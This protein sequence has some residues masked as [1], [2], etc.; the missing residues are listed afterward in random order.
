MPTNPAKDILLGVAVG[1]AIGVPVEFLD[2]SKMQANPL[3]GLKGYGTYNLPPGTWSDDTSLTLCLA[4]AL[5]EQT[6]DPELVGKYF[7]RW[8]YRSYWTANGEVFD[9]GITTREAIQRISRGTPATLAGGLDERENGNGSLMRILPLVL[10][11]KNLPIEERFTITRDISSITHGHIRA[12]IGC[13]YYLEF[14]RRLLFGED[15]FAIY[16]DLQQVIPPFLA[17][18]GI[19]PSEIDTYKRI[20]KEDITQASTESML[21]HGYVVYATEVAIWSLLT[22]TSYKDAILQAINLGND[23]D[24][25]AAITG[26]LAALLYGHDTI[27]LDWLNALARKSDIENL[28][29]LLHKRYA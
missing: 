25:N 12:V 19:L 22:T 17:T 18:L 28:A 7:T 8:L 26:G 23:T 29:W 24:T 16:T 5:T 10:Y 3:T 6:L 21:G 20:L 15:K 14:A 2:R 9:V 11:I 1:D 13:F 4:E 27:P